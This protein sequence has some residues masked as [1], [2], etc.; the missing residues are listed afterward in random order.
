MNAPRFNPSHTAY[1]SIYLPQR[2]GRLSCRAVVIYR[3]GLAVRRQSPIQVVTGLYVEQDQR[4]TIERNCHF[5]ADE[6]D[7][8]LSHVVL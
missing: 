6:H 3:D 7:Y 5:G 4:V 1:Y 8:N 2:D